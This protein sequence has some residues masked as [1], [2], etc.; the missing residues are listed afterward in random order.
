M[1]EENGT[2]KD[3]LE[4]IEKMCDQYED[5]LHLVKIQLVEV[6]YNLSQDDLQKMSSQQIYGLC[7]EMSKYLTALQKEVN[8]QTG[9]FNWA[10]R[11]LSLL[12]D[13]ESYNQK[14]TYWQERRAQ[15]LINNEAAK[16]LERMKTQ[17]K[18]EIDRLSYL[19]KRIEYQIDFASQIAFGKRKE[20]YAQS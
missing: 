3:E 20:E 18:M 2:I 14:A 16:K 15:V 7:F 8:R 9:R 12:M 4:K 11:Q 13:R 1:S 10:D 5:K 6:D 17:F 19:P